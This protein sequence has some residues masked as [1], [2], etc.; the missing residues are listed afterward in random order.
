MDRVDSIPPEVRR[1]FEASE[2]RRQELAALP[3]EQKIRMVVELQRMAA[4]VLRAR[5]LDVLPWELDETPE[6]AAQT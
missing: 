6:E 3:W 2:A 5:G 1:L 4:P